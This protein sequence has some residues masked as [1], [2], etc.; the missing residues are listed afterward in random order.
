MARADKRILKLFSRIPQS[1]GENGLALSGRPPVTEVSQQYRRLVH[2]QLA[3]FCDCEELHHL[4]VYS[5]LQGD[6]GKL[7]LV[8]LG[9]WPDTPDQLPAAEV[10]GQLRLPGSCR[11][12]WPLRRDAV[13]LGALRAE[14]HSPPWSGALR[15]R[16]QACAQT[17]TE[18]LCLDHD[19]QG[20]QTTLLQQQEQLGALVHQLRNPLA[21]LR[22]F[23]Q[24][25]LRRM[26]PAARQ[27]PLVQSLLTEQRQL[28]RYIDAMGVLTKP[29]ATPNP[30][31][32]CQ[33]LL[34]PASTSGD[35]VFSP[36][37]LADRLSGLADRAEARAVLQGRSWTASGCWPQWEGATDS[38]AEIV[39]NLLD[40]AFRYATTGRP[41]G[42]IWSVGPRATDLA[43]GL[44]I[45]VWDGGE[46]IPPE[47]RDRIFKQGERG[48]R[49]SGTDGTGRGLALARGLAGALGG[50]LT[51]CSPPSALDPSL[52][53][54]GNAFCL[55]LPPSAQR[56]ITA[57]PISR[58][59]SDSDHS[60]Q[61]P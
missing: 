43:S 61:A 34:L 7:H 48:A 22:T 39:A 46:D 28:G 3:Q 41:I 31:D 53:G 2:H 50:H 44:W 24:L 17:L 32:R 11:R 52:P 5:T 42:L 13:L 60:T 30:T 29:P 9:Q 12:W 16:I 57:R 6:D 45:C 40:N 18:A 15:E 36:Q 20:L 8:P 49:S 23:A 47:E 27:R 1:S 26:D 59:A 19:R 33:P 58:R 35:G 54:T 25:L 14:I 38:V 4:V 10:D 55:T 21:A 56:P 37:A 51:L